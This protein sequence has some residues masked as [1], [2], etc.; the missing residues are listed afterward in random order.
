[1]FFPRLRRQAKW[2]FIFLAVVF[3]VG[4]VGFGV[5]SGSTGIGDLLHGNFSFFGTRHGSVSSHEKQARLQIAAR[6]ND[7]KGYRD[8]ATAL[9][10][11]G[12]DDEAIAPLERYTQL[13]PKDADALRELAG[14]Y[15]H[16]AD[17]FRTAASI[18]QQSGGNVPASPIFNPS[19]TSRLGQALGQDPI[20][21]AV[22]QQVN[23]AV[24]D[25]VVKLRTA[26]GK[27]IDT[28]KRLVAINPSDPTIQFEL[29]QTAEQ[30]GDYATAVAAYKRF[31]KLSPDDPTVPAVKQRIKQLER[32]GVSAPAA[33]G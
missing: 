7:P 12:K 21:S 10:A 6:P 20:Q 2:M 4:F 28:Y 26:E 29:A 19:A 15:L 23:G 18:A 1:M 32:G 16:Q 8:L 11:R 9:E 3:A 33:S 14:L 13:R 22:G 27:A 30:T 25:N 31:I 17:N 5:G 24:N